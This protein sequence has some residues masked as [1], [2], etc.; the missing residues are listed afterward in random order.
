MSDISKRLFS[1]YPGGA[2]MSLI[3]RRSRGGVDPP[4]GRLVRRKI[5]Y[6]GMRNHR[7]TYPY[8]RGIC[9]S[10]FYQDAKT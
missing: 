5:I 9:R 1:K 7:L 3:H 10:I 8:V 6:K 4:A 2:V